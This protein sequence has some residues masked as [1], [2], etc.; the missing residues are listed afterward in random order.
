M[1]CREIYLVVNFPHYQE[2]LSN[3]KGILV[4]KKHKSIQAFKH[5][6]KNAKCKNGV[7]QVGDIEPT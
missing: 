5:L 3:K 1:V 4:V 6:N 7:V 2:F